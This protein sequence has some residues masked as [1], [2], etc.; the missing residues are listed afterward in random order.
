MGG[1]IAG[2]KSTLRCSF[3]KCQCRARLGAL[4]LVPCPIQVSA[5]QSCPS[6]LPGRFDSSPAGSTEGSAPGNMNVDARRLTATSMRHMVLVVLLL[7]LCAARGVTVEPDLNGIFYSHHR[8]VE[9]RSG[10]GIGTST[11]KSGTESSASCSASL[12]RPQAGNRNL[13]TS[14]A[15]SARPSRRSNK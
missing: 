6:H 1:S 7:M 10:V 12:E 14:Y 11:R 8:P 13:M 3:G 2:Y 15:L 9:R 5:I 4:L